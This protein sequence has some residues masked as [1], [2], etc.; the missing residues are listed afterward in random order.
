MIET[1]KK[2]FEWLQILPIEAKIIVTIT[3]ISIAAFF[4]V[5]LWLP[6]PSEVSV[7]KIEIILKDIEEIEKNW[8]SR[9][10]EIEPL[11]K[12]TKSYI[13]KCFPEQELEIN[14]ILN[15]TDASDVARVLKTQLQFVHDKLQ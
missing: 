7:Q 13:G 4:V 3:I 12:R 10:Q 15:G 8:D 14:K 2:T 11:A 6:C 5:M 9:W 1:F